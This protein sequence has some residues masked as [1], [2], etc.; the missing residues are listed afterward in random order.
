LQ[1]PSKD[2]LKKRLQQRG[3]ETEETLNTRISNAQKEI[4]QAIESGIFP[5]FITNDNREQF[6]E[7]AT[8]YIE[9]LYQLRQRPKAT[10]FFVLG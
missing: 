8:A 2:E 1:P 10:V 4:D 7:V 6:L 3:T 9:G 5:K